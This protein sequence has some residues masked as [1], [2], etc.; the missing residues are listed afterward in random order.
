MPNEK[1]NLLIHDVTTTKVGL[2]FLFVTVV[3]FG[4]ALVATGTSI[5]ID[6]S[7]TKA[8]QLEAIKQ[9]FR[10]TV[11]TN[12]DSNEKANPG[13]V[14]FYLN[15]KFAGA[16]TENSSYAAAE[17]PPPEGPLAISFLNSSSTALPT[18][19]QFPPQ[20]IKLTADTGAL[21]VCTPA[22]TGGSGEQTVW[23]TRT[24]STFYDEAFTRLARNC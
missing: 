23:V 13:V 8:R 18:T 19:V 9:A 17:E 2:A 20:T 14:A 1:T 16:I 24:G 10:A 4:L 12:A 15:G 11:I 21:T 7:A 3:S 22:M 6:R 5:M